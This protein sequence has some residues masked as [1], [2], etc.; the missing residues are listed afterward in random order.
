MTS[1]LYLIRSSSRISVALRHVKLIDRRTYAVIGSM[2]KSIITGHNN[3][4]I[5]EKICPCIT[6]YIADNGQTKNLSKTKCTAPFKSLG[7][8]II[9]GVIIFHMTLTIVTVAIV[10]N[11]WLGYMANN[12][13]TMGCDTNDGQ[14]THSIARRNAH[15]R[16]SAGVYNFILSINI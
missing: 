1:G 16:F 8:L 6:M 13:G 5:A 4:V 10:K 14:L 3:A 12:T 11:I 7:E 2:K 9:F 15:V